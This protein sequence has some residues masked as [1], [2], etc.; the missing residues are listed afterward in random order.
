MALPDAFITGIGQ[1]QVGIRLERH[2]LLLT[3]DAIREALDNAGLTIAD[4][5]GISTYPGKASVPLVR[6]WF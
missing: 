4:I 3:V 1:S 5:D 6:G 2:P